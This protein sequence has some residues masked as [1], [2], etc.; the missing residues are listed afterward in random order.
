[1]Y[2]PNAAKTGGFFSLAAQKQVE[3]TVATET[4]NGAEITPVTVGGYPA[5]L[6]IRDGGLIIMAYDTWTMGL[7]ITGG[8]PAVIAVALPQLAE[9]ALARILKT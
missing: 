2:A 6:A 4:D 5:T 1:M 9:A 3:V 8:D 7:A